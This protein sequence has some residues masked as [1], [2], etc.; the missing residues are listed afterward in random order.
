M[1]RIRFKRGT[2]CSVQAY[3]DAKIGEPIYDYEAGQL[4]IKDIYGV[5]KPIGSQLVS[6]EGP[7]SVYPGGSYSYTINNYSSFVNYEVSHNLDTD[8][9][10]TINEKTINLDLG[11]SL[12]QEN[13]DL[14]ISV[15]GSQQIFNID[16]AAESVVTPTITSHSSGDT[17]VSVNPTFTTSDFATDPSGLD[18]HDSTD[19]Q[20]ASNSDFSNIIEENLDSSDLTSW[21]PSTTLSDTTTYYLR[22]KHRGNTIGESGWAQTSFETEETTGEVNLT[23]DDLDSTTESDPY[24]ASESGDVYTFEFDADQRLTAYISNFSSTH[25]L[26]FINSPTGSDGDLNVTNSDY[27]DGSAILTVG[28]VDV[29]LS[30]LPDATFWDASSFKNIYGDSSLV[31]E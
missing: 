27:S 24:D 22:V 7:T 9:T 10:V 29:Y 25:T 14:I 11:S 3:E 28:D 6:L 31:I 21:T 18:T 23:N 30:N 16:F 8:T 26:K 13:F 12:G 1:G 20:L 5:L 15:D 17:G 2:T 19:W 4:Y